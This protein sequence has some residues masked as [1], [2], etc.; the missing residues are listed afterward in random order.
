MRDKTYRVDLPDGSY[1]LILA[2]S[3]SKAVSHVASQLLAVRV[4]T[5][6]DLQEGS[7]DGVAVEHPGAQEIIETSESPAN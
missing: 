4:A 5:K 2:N 7:E 3:R 6:D 1:R